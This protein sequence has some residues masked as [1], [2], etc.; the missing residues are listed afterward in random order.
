M[1]QYRGGDGSSK[2]KAII[3]LGAENEFEGVDASI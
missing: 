3:I 2:E 1:L